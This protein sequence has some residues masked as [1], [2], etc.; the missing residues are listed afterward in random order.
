MVPPPYF[1]RGMDEQEFNEKYSALLEETIDQLETG[2]GRRVFAKLLELTTSGDLS[3]EIEALDI[4]DRKAIE[5]FNVRVVELHKEA[6]AYHEGM[7]G[8][9]RQVQRVVERAQAVEPGMGPNPTIEQAVAVLKRHGEPLGISE[10]ALET[11]VAIPALR[12]AVQDDLDQFGI[13]ITDSFSMHL[14]DGATLHFN[15]TEVQALRALARWTKE[16][17]AFEG[18]EIGILALG[19]MVKEKGAQN[20]LDLIE[21][22]DTPYVRECKEKARKKAFEDLIDEMVAE[23]RLEEGIG[24]NGKRYTRLNPDHPANQGYL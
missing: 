18:G 19:Q 24:E 4:D 8:F 10:E 7:L 3:D 22:R 21:D 15:E 9:V 17:K 13:P 2:E 5:R 16:N 1:R 23:G 20:T 6:W 12:K 11:T 14:P